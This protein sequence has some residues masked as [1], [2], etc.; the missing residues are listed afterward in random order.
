M[1]T[2]LS[3]AVKLGVLSGRLIAAMESIL[4]ELWWNAFQKW[5]GWNR[6]RIKEARRPQEMSSDSGE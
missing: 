3:D 1:A 6:G 2:L 4:T 5:M